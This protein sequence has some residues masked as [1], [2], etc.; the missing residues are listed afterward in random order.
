LID[1]SQL[2]NNGEWRIF[3]PPAGL[4]SARGVFNSSKIKPGNAT[5]VLAGLTSPP[6]SHSSQIKAD[7]TPK[8]AATTTKMVD[9]A[10]ICSLPTG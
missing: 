1:Q 10:K 6:T 5:P 9:K 3:K 4:E 2:P 7:L 8:F